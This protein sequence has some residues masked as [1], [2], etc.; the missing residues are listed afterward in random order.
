VA[1]SLAAALV[2]QGVSDQRVLIPRAAEAR[3]VLPRELE[4]A[5]A[6]VRVVALYDTVREELDDAQRERLAGAHYVTFTSSSTVRNL[7]DAIGGAD[8]FPEAAR[9]VSI[10]PITT[11]TAG[12]HGLDVAVEAERHDVEGVVEALLR[13]ALAP[14]PTS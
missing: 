5:G 7:L 14:A 13:D 4:Q 1:E 3:D 11:Q 8:R 2:A 10:G 12:E 6:D 9:V